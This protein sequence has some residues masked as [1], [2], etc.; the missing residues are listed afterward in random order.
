MK[1]IAVVTG[2]STK[3]INKILNDTPKTIRPS[4]VHKLAQGLKTT[5]EALV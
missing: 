4:T 2:V 1:E 5:V 3:T